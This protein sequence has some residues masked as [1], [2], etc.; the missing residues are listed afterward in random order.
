[1]M[2]V[3]SALIVIVVAG[4]SGSHV[5]P[6]DGGDW[7]EDGGE[8]VDGGPADAG[9]IMDADLPD[10]IAPRCPEVP[11][12]PCLVLAS[13]VV[14]ATGDRGIDG[15]L[16]G[17]AYASGPAVL[18]TYASENAPT[19]PPS[20]VRWAIQ[21]LSPTGELDGTAAFL[22]GRFVSDSEWGGDLAVSDGDL[23]AGWQEARYDSSFTP[24]A[25]I[26]WSTFTLRMPPGMAF[27]PIHSTERSPPG[28]DVTVAAGLVVTTG[29][30][31]GLLISRV[32][33][34]GEPLRI[35]TAL[36]PVFELAS[37]ALGPNRALVV[38][39]E[40]HASGLAA[41]IATE[42]AIVSDTSIEARAR[43]FEPSLPLLSPDAR[44]VAVGDELWIARLE[45]DRAH[46]RESRIRVAHLDSSL[47]RLGPDR[48]FAGWGGLTPAG[49]ALVIWHGAPWLVWRTLD[50]RYG[51][52]TVLY[53][54]PIPE[55]ACGFDVSDPAVV[56]RPGV[57]A[58]R[59]FAT[60]SAEALWVAVPQSSG[61]GTADVYQFRLCD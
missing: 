41:E 61:F 45:V 13:Q 2:R 60:S 10:G 25:A 9:S 12:A 16:H 55:P 32:G 15:H 7:T 18:L 30:P 35:D 39:S 24:P 43:V 48:W 47:R 52:N 40:D 14:F 53:A 8:L 31:D 34:T 21:R 17:L 26:A 46:L 42:A 6:G 36:P 57:V 49:M 51:A 19:L 59:L 22:S 33:D 11:P 58:N 23:L 27:G 29:A 5:R 4:C 1:M 28:D 37:V 44:V 20:P 3:A 56:W 54:R 38:W 50:A